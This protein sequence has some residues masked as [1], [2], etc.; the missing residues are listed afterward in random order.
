MIKNSGEFFFINL[1]NL[2]FYIPIP[3]IIFVIMNIKN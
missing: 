3:M 1:R 2:N